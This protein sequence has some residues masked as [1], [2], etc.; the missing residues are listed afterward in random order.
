MPEPTSNDMTLKDFISQVKGLKEDDPSAELMSDESMAMFARD[1]VKSVVQLHTAGWIHRDINPE[2]VVINEYGNA[3]LKTPASAQRRG[4]KGGPQS[5]GTKGYQALEIDA[6]STPKPEKYTYNRK[7]DAYALGQT[8]GSMIDVL[9][10][11]PNSPAMRALKT[12]SADMMELMPEYRSRADDI[13]PCVESLHAQLS[14][15]VKQCSTGSMMNALQPEGK[16]VK[17]PTTVE[18]SEDSSAVNSAEDSSDQENTVKAK[19]LEQAVKAATQ[20]AMSEQENA[21]PVNRL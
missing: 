3:S 6:F 4:K 14:K 18:S 5:Y 16:V 21:H 13:L 17:T 8:M 10:D 20:A 9:A 19:V 1:L 12:W 11:T 2:T 7:T 15:A